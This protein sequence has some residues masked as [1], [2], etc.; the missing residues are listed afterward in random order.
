MT[1]KPE[2]LGW[3]GMR[4]RLMIRERQAAKL[5]AISA[6]ESTSA[7]PRASQEVRSQETPTPALREIP[8]EAELAAHILLR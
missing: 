2:L 4:I 1:T 3:E 7:P 6:P 8:Q 5:P